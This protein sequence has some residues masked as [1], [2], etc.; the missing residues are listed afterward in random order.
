MERKRSARCTLSAS[1]ASIV[2]NFVDVDLPELLVWLAILINTM[3]NW[4]SNIR[5]YWSDD[6]SMGAPYIKSLMSRN[7][8]LEICRILKLNDNDEE[9]TI[10]YNPDNPSHAKQKKYW[11][12]WQIVIKNVAALFNFS[13][14]YFVIDETMI[15]YKGKIGF[16][17]YQPQKPVKHGIKVYSLCCACPGLKGAMVN[18]ELYAGFSVEEEGDDTG[19][20]NAVLL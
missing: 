8:F 4:R 13:G 19:K 2:E 20:L 15:A 1:S 16:I 17:Q 3:Y 10:N 7:R 6:E 18:A 9:P 14:T 12:F 11:D 5:D